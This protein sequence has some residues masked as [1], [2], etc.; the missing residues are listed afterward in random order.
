MT[1]P[2]RDWL[3]AVALCEYGWASTEELAEASLAW[4]PAAPDS[5]ALYYLADDAY[6]ETSRA[7]DVWTWVDQVF[8]DLGYPKPARGDLRW[9]AIR[10]MIGRAQLPEDAER[11]TLFLSSMAF[12]A[13]MEG[14]HQRWRTPLRPSGQ[15]SRQQECHS[16]CGQ[17]PD[18]HTSGRIPSQGQK[19]TP[20][21][22]Q[23]ERNGCLNSL[24]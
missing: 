24:Y 16:R 9:I 17:R 5:A 13:Q 1:P 14:R 6:R 12:E 10:C 3:C 19:L 20:L 23:P 7:P 18:T 22:Y 2:D 15:V 21:G 4:L 11:L 8:D